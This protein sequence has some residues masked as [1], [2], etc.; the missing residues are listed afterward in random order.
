VRSFPTPGHLPQVLPPHY[1]QKRQK[2]H[3]TQ[4]TAFG[5]TIA[6]EIPRAFPSIQTGRPPSPK[7]RCCQKRNLI[8]EKCHTPKNCQ[9]TQPTWNSIMTGRKI[10]GPVLQKPCKLPKSIRNFQKNPSIPTRES[11]PQHP[12][13]KPFHLENSTVPREGKNSK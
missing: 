6:I 11:Q 1:W 4:T 12:H 3:Q 7:E 5:Q 9:S 10:S 2:S 8:V 13:H